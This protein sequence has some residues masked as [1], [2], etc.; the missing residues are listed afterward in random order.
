[1]SV[2][3]NLLAPLV[4]KMGK[5]IPPWNSFFQQFTQK[6]PATVEITVGASPFSYQANV[7]GTVIVRGGTVSSIV[8]IR[9]DVTIANPVIDFTG[10][11]S[12]LVSIGDIV[13][14]TYSSIPT[15]KFLAQ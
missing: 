8:L 12:V 2:V 13:K 5:V 14:I 1:M 15:I 3:P 9:G 4:D 10:A 6:A 7:I 11:L